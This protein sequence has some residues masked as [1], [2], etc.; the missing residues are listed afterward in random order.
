MP[1][2][3]IGRPRSNH[4]VVQSTLPLGV[5]LHPSILPACLCSWTGHGH[6]PVPDSLFNRLLLTALNS[7]LGWLHPP[8]S[9]VCYIHYYVMPTAGEV[10]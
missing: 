8:A 1:H 6:G 3:R 2:R 5:G 9:P 7:S 10:M 4:N